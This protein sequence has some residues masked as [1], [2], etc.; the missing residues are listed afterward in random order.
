MIFEVMDP[1]GRRIRLTRE[2]WE[3]HIVDEHPELEGQEERL[4]E[5]VEN[6]DFIYKE[7]DIRFFYRISEISLMKYHDLYIRAVIRLES[8][9]RGHVVTAHLRD[10]PTGR[11]IEWIRPRR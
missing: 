2:R 4:K 6:P 8:E 9:R 11:E 5:A 1:L 7:D 3:D 10:K